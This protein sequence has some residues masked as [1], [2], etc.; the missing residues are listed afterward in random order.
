MENVTTD[1]LEIT[2]EEGIYP[3]NNI[4]NGKAMRPKYTLAITFWLMSKMLIALAALP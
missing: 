3:L 2:N 1:S 4:K